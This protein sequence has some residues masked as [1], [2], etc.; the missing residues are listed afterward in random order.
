MEDTTQEFK[1]HIEYENDDL[2]E[3]PNPIYPDT[4]YFSHLKYI[5]ISEIDM[6]DQLPACVVLKEGDY[7]KITT[8]ERTEVGQLGKITE[9]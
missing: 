2:L 6:K 1:L 3:L 5:T 7:T 8:P 9:I 4:T